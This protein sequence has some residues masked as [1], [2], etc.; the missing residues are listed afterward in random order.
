M[1]P[2]SSDQDISLLPLVGD[3]LP[4]I[5]QDMELAR[6]MQEYEVNKLSEVAKVLSC[7]AAVYE[8]ATMFK[9]SIK[10]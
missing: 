3:R 2:L 5:D 8:M 10:S 4:I 9:V 7:V 6:L 1:I